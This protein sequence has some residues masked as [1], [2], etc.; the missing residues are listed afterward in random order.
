MSFVQLKKLKKAFEGAAQEFSR[1]LSTPSPVTWEKERDMLFKAA[2][3]NDVET[4]RRIAPK[5][6]NDFMKWATKKGSPLHVAQLAQREGNLGAFKELVAFGAD[7]NENYG[8]GWT[9]LLAAVKFKQKA[10][11]DFLFNKGADVNAQG[12][13]ECDT[14]GGSSYNCTFTALHLAIANHD[15][16][17]VKKLLERGADPGKTGTPEGPVGSMTA[18]TYALYS[19][20]YAIADTIQRADIL[21]TEYLA[22]QTSSATQQPSVQTAPPPSL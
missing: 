7:V 12:T 20:Q 13:I 17:T 3:K 11:A 4:I 18:L 9:P 22:K 6:P 2:A 16:D 14:L 1:V 19:K 21:R 8:D 5:Y 15:A 10:L